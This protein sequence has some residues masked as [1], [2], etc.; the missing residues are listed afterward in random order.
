MLFLQIE[1]DGLE[2]D[3]IRAQ[4]SRSSSNCSLHQSIPKSTKLT[5]NRCIFSSPQ[6]HR[7]HYTA[8]CRWRLKFR[9]HC[10][11]KMHKEDKRK[12]QPY[13][14]H[15]NIHWQWSQWKPRKSVYV[16]IYLHDD[17]FLKVGNI[18]TLVPDSN[19]LH[20]R[21]IWRKEFITEAASNLQSNL[22]WNEWSCACRGQHY[23]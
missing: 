9:E 8:I 2:K 19:T 15:R 23:C 6:R 12:S 3:E 20:S 7:Q 21:S 10:R 1:S 16:E 4:N 22:G 18:A 14:M 17:L 13:R 5:S 11:R